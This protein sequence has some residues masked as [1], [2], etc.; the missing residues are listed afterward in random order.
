M[1][2]YGREIAWLGQPAHRG[3]A[4]TKLWPALSVLSAVACPSASRKNRRA[5]A[6]SSPRHGPVSGNQL[7]G[8]TGSPVV[9]PMRG[10]SGRMLAQ[11]DGSPS[12]QPH[13]STDNLGKYWYD[14]G[15]Q[16]T[17]KS[18]CK[19]KKCAR[20]TRIYYAFWDL[21]IVFWPPIWAPNRIS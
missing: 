1:G 5:G 21:K 18:H 8:N 11:S 2:G 20:L 17:G 6:P 7:R 15:G 13:D 4:S 10:K 12:L 19:T 9:S 16:N 14:F 3:F